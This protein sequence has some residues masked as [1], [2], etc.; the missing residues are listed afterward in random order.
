LKKLLKEI[1]DKPLDEQASIL[2]EEH[3]IWRSGSEQIDDIMVLG[4]RLS[5]K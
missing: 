1:H 2:R 5:F 4:V 3:E